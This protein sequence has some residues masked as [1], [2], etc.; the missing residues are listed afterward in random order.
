MA[1]PTP[2]NPVKP[3]ATTGRRSALTAVLV[4]ALTHTAAG[5]GS[6]YSPDYLSGSAWSRLLPIDPGT[7]DLGPL[8]S[9]TRMLSR[10]IRQDRDFGIL[11]QGLA[12]DGSSWFARRDAGITAVFPRSAYVQTADGEVAIIPPDTTFVIGEPA[13]GYSDSLGLSHTAHTFHDASNGLRIDGRVHDRLGGR[14]ESRMDPTRDTARPW[15]ETTS[16][17]SPKRGVRA[18]LRTAGERE[19]ARR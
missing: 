14:L 10:N 8:G 5:Q 2:H 9:Q 18:L 13:L 16:P 15:L 17:R 7:A 19:R 3:T 12:R 1:P 11:Y 4:C 6:P